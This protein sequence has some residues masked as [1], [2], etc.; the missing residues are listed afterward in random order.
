MAKHLIL[1]HGRS[2][3][4]GKGDLAANWFG[5]IKHGLKRDNHNKALD[6]YSKIT[7]TFVYYGGIS[8]KILSRTGKVYDMEVD[9][10]DRGA[11][12]RQTR[13]DS[14]YRHVSGM[15]YGVGLYLQELFETH[16]AI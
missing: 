4:P 13:G 11:C 15:A 3:K 2:F 1:I 10:K 14:L 16:Q 5:A 12:L 8:N 7:K 6:V 9:V